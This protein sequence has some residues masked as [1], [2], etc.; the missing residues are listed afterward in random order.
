M[1]T[2]IEKDN[3]HYSVYYCNKDSTETIIKN[4]F[5]IIYFEMK[6]FNE[7]FE[8]NYK[9]LFRI[10]NDKIY[11]L[12]IFKQNSYFSNY[13]EMGNIFLTKYFCL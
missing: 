3:T 11:F 10:K 2:V 8:L 12:V 6:Q 5:P 4:E 9:D 1:E 7:K 13:F